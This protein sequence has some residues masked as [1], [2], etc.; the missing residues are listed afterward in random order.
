MKLLEMC[1]F[2]QVLVRTDF[3]HIANVILTPTSL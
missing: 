2:R 1:G 3:D